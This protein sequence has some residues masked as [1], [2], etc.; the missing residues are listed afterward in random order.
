[1]PVSLF[2]QCLVLHF[3]RLTALDFVQVA[4]APERKLQ[5]QVGQVGS[6]TQKTAVC[7]LCALLTLVATERSNHVSEEEPFSVLLHSSGVW[8]YMYARSFQELLW[9]RFLLTER[10]RSVLCAAI[11]FADLHCRAL[12]SWKLLLL[13][14]LLWT[15]VIDNG[16][17]NRP[18]S[19]P[20]VCCLCAARDIRDYESTQPTA[21]IGGSRSRSRPT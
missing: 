9:F 7:M 19:L 13:L 2:Q 21:N 10:L 6:A 3:K 14:R 16:A 20:Q 4:D 12:G 5:P 17:E 11:G 1:M 15:T 8:M 18:V